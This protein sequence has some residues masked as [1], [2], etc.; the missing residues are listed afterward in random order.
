MN[1]K[2]TENSVNNATDNDDNNQSV[3]QSIQYPV[4]LNGLSL[5][6]WIAEHRHTL[7]RKIETEGAVLLRGLNIISSTQFGKIAATLFGDELADYSNRSTPRTE[8]KGKVFTTTEYPAEETIPLHNENSYSHEW[9]M[10]AAFFCLVPPPVGG[11]TP[12]ADSRLIYQNIPSH[13]REKFEQKGVMYL[14]NYASVGLPWQEVFQVETKQEVEDFCQQHAIK[15]EWQED[16]SLRTW[17]VCPAVQVH[18]VTGE[19]VWFNQAHLF[20]VSNHDEENRIALMGTFTEEQLPRHAY[21]GDG[22][23]I[24]EEY[25][26]IIRQVYL[27]QK[28]KFT[29][30]RGD[31]LIADNM[32]FCHGREPFEGS[33]RIILAMAGHNCIAKQQQLGSKAA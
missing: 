8:L 1:T 5:K 25:L 20:H 29:W 6:Q 18:P 11:E 33:R 4:E 3:V 22:E 19:K 21:Y 13:I 14:R 17:Q 28:I 26:Q 23:P 10:K 24:E 15:F 12:V 27:D 32:L 30:Q 7:I 9:V 31:L 16:E 2:I